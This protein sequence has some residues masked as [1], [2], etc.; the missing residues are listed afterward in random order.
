MVRLSGPFFSGVANYEKRTTLYNIWRSIH[1]WGV[2]GSRPENF[3]ILSSL[4]AGEGGFSL[5]YVMLCY[6]AHSPLGLFS[7]RLHQVYILRLLKL[8]IFTTIEIL[9][10]YICIYPNPP[11]LLPCGRK[12]E[13]P[14]KT[15][16]FRR[17]VD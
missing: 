3:P 4:E 10:P 15:H 2:W 16:D 13:R 11:C 9:L 6:S 1:C 7:G 12:P 8:A 17:S 14:E 5:C